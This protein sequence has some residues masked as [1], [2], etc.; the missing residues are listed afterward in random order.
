[1]NSDLFLLEVHLYLVCKVLDDKG[2]VGEPRLLKQGTDLQVPE[3][4][5]QPALIRALRELRVKAQVGAGGSVT[6]VATGANNSDGSEA[7][8]PQQSK[9]I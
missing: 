8:S 6:K 3:E 9:T 4:L 7:F 2:L 1:M 5:L